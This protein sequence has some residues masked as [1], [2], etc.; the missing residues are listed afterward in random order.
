MNISSG[1]DFFKSETIW[2]LRKNILKT[3][4]FKSVDFGSKLDAFKFQLYYLL[5]Y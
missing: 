3:H 4:E 2:V 1:E 5:T